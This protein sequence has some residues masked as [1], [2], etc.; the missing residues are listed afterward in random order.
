MHGTEVSLDLGMPSD[1]TYMPTQH[2][3]GV[4]SDA[5]CQ[6]T[7]CRGVLSGALRPPVQSV[8]LRHRNSYDEMH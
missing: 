3:R 1:A 2:C 6:S 8:L 5:L 4:P 7:Q